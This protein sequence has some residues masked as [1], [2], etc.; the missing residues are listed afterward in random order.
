M[1]VPRR[2][3]PVIRKIRYQKDATDPSWTEKAR[4][5]FTVEAVGKHR[6]LKGNCP[7]CKHAMDFSWSPDGHLGR[8]TTTRSRVIS[9]VCL[10]EEDHPKAPDGTKGCGAIWD[11]D[12]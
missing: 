6:F 2:L 11:I 12:A 9:L 5:M 1:L 7:R 3:S 10:C 8:N 4:L